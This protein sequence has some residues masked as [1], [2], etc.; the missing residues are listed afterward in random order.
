MKLRSNR[1][2]WYDHVM[3][4][5]ESHTSRRMLSMDGHRRRGEQRQMNCMRNEIEGVYIKMIAA[6]GERICTEVT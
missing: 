2:A 5:D 3:R 4:R 6:T 1:L